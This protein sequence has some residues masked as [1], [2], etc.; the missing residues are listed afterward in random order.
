MIVKGDRVIVLKVEIFLS[1]L[2]YYK[3]I[4]LGEG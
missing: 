2:L 1:V 4:L 3:I